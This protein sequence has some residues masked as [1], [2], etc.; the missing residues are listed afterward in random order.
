MGQQLAQ[1]DQ[2]DQSPS[3]FF[4]GVIFGMG[5][6]TYIN[7][8]LRRRRVLE[9]IRVAFFSWLYDDNEEEQGVKLIERYRKPIQLKG[10]VGDKIVTT[11][12]NTS[13]TAG[14]GTKEDEEKETAA[15]TTGYRCELI[16]PDWT[17]TSNYE[18]TMLTLVPGA[19][20]LAKETNCVEFYYVMKGT[21][22][23][24]LSS[25]GI[26]NDRDG[27]KDGDTKQI[28]ISAGD[29]FIVDPGKKRGFKVSGRTDFVLLRTTDAT[30]SATTLL[31]SSGDDQIEFQQDKSRLSS[32]VAVAKAA[33]NKVEKMV[34]T[35]YES[36]EEATETVNV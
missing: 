19:E 34:T 25:S 26:V 20:L 18:V 22:T 33:L 3:Y 35:Y 24:V 9:R 23:F 36:K 30:A 14:S 13:S 10:L 11:T 32:T 12:T 17:L 28:Q 16:S 31:R 1:Q 4:S 15:T 7:Y 8:E 6:S 27:D 2:G 29:A 5:L 21:G